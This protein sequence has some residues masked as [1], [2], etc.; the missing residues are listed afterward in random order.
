MSMALT[1]LA[2][3]LTT[4]QLNFRNAISDHVVRDILFTMDFFYPGSQAVGIYY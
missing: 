1:A 3:G 4:D 2:P